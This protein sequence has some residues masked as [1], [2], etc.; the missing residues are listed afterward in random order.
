[1]ILSQTGVAMQDPQGPGTFAR[2]RRLGIQRSCDRLGTKRYKIPENLVT[3]AIASAPWRILIYDR[4]GN[5]T[6]PLELGKVVF[7]LEGTPTSMEEV[8]WTLE[9]LHSTGGSSMPM[10]QGQ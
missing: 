10:S 3:D 2:G 6:M 1:M 4:L 5:P 9:C 8:S 7:G